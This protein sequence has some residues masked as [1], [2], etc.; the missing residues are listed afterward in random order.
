MSEADRLDA[1]DLWEEARRRSEHPAPF[2]GEPTGP[3]SARRLVVAGVALA[4]FVSSGVFAW[5]ALRP[6]DVPKQQ[7]IEEPGEVFDDLPA[8]W[9]ELAPPPDVRTG[10]ATAW[11]GTQLIV[12]GGY[13]GFE[14]SDVGADG[15]AF[16]AAADTWQELPPSPLAA[17]AL[18]AS[19]WTGSELLIWGGWR[20]TYGYEFAEGFFGDGAAYDPETQS[21]RV[22]PPAPI[23]GRAPFSVWT[24]SE[25][26]VWGTALRVEHRERDGAAYNPEIDRWHP[27][28]DA[29]IELTDATATWTGEEMIVF[30]AALAGGNH[31]ETQSAIGAAYDPE[32]DIWREIS[33]SR[34]SPQAST[35]AWNGNELI[36]WDYLNDSAAYDPA[37]DTWR[38]LP[39]I[40]LDDSEC[41]PES[42]AVGGFVLGEYCGA[43]T[44]FD[45]DDD[46]WVEVPLPE[47][48][49]GRPSLDFEFVSAGPVFLGPAQRYG[50]TSSLSSLRMFA[51]RP[52]SHEASS[53]VEPT[54]FVPEVTVEGDRAQ[55]DVTFPD[56]SSAT[57]TYPAELDLTSRGLQPDVSYIWREDPPSRHPIVFLHGPPGVDGAYVEGDDPTAT[58]PLPGG[59][60]AALWRA[61][62][63]ES[64]R[65][66][67]VSWWLV[68]RTESWSALAALRNADDAEVLASELEVR[69]AA[70]GLPVAITGGPVY[71]AEYAGEDEGPV[72]AFGDVQPDPSVVSDLDALILLSPEPCS[73]GPEFDDPPEYASICL[74]DG[75]VFVGI[76]G[77]EAFLKS[78]LD[79]LRVEAFSPASG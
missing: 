35:A 6:E 11:T 53:P 32:T 5:Q 8:G 55:V 48:D 19:A 16:D 29:P 4:V 44:L 65:L 3:S 21:W 71:L 62:E 41:S 36:A 60:E 28:A 72:L 40:P 39:R 30:G 25:L 12:W 63:P 13:T 38:P 26:L 57:I 46:R 56:G 73:G 68:Y 66:R 47:Q 77:D 49:A 59:G 22:L 34:L 31:S 74:A 70:T 79:G 10:A 45:P 17:R 9:T 54:P 37:T 7:P 64:F 1:P 43:L 15:F 24:G 61:S 14:E 51:Y 42:A 23:E 75:Q 27:I 58:F 33:R 18:T 2:P 76:Y 69:E 67:S 52:G 50:D 78:V 20:G